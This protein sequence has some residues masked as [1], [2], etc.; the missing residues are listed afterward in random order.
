MRIDEAVLIGLF[1]EG[2]LYGVFMITFAET[3]RALISKSGSF[4]TAKTLRRTFLAVTCSFFIVAT[5]DLII[6]LVHALDAFVHHQGVG[7]ASQYFANIAYWTNSPVTKVNPIQCSFCCHL[8][9]R[10]PMLVDLDCNSD[11]TW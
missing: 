6:N 3:L 2:V 1:C 7:G 9:S 8:C 5:L 4:Q 10:T 11:L